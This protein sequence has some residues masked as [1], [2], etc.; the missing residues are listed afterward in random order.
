VYTR[1][2]VADGSPIYGMV[3]MCV[4][5]KERVYVYVYAAGNSPTE[6]VRAVYVCV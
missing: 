6:C 4:C 1:V 5:A 3:I 2:R